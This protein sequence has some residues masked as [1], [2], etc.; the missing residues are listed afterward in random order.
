MSKNSR[1]SL[2]ACGLNAR[3]AAGA[4][5]LLGVSI[6]VGPYV[7]LNYLDRGSV[8]DPAVAQAL[9]RFLML[10]CFLGIGVSLLALWAWFMAERT[11]FDAD[12]DDR[13]KGIPPRGRRWMVELRRREFDVGYRRSLR[14]AQE[15]C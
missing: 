9:A 3:L 14:T 2:R 10:V 5:G 6:A 13:R 1:L 4:T 12:E 11:L 15:E 7:F 8:P